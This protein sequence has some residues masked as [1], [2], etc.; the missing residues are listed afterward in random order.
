M[1]SK[2]II[3]HSKDGKESVVV[4]RPLQ[5]RT[6]PLT[7]T[8][9][10]GFIPS[11]K[12]GCEGQV[13]EY[14]SQLEHDFL[15]L[16]DYDPNCLDLQPQPIEFVYKTVSGNLVKFY[17]DIWAVFTD[18]KEYL[19]EVK[20]E[21]HL[22]KLQQDENW[23]RKLAVI[24]DECRK[25]GWIFQIITEKRIRCPRLTNIKQTLTAAKH[26]SLANLKHE[27]QEK[28]ILKNLRKLLEKNKFNLRELSRSLASISQFS[29]EETISILKYQIYYGN[30]FI[31]WD[32]PLEENVVSLNEIFIIPTYKLPEIETRSDNGLLIDED[33]VNDSYISEN[34]TNWLTDSQLNLIQPLIDVFGEKVSKKDIRTL[35]KFVNR[36][37]SEIN[38]YYIT[39]KNQRKYEQRL[40]LITPLINK[41]GKEGK[42]KP[43]ENYCKDQLKMTDSKMQKA[44]KWYIIWRKFDKEGLF[45]KKRSPYKSRLDPLVEQLLQEAVEGWNESSGRQIKAAYESFMIECLKKGFPEKKIPSLM[46]FWDRTQKLPAVEVHGKF[47]AKKSITVKRGLTATYREGLHPGCVIQIDHTQADIW[48]VDD[49]TKQPFC[50][51]WITLAVDVFSRSIWGIFVSVDPPS[52]ESVAQCLLSGLVPK[53]MLKDWQKFQHQMLKDGID[54]EHYQW[55]SSGFPARIQVD[56]GKDFMANS[57]KSFCMRLNIT[58]EFRPIKTPEYGGFV[59]SVWDTINDAIRNDTLLGRVFSLPKSREP[60]KRPKFRTPNGYD[61]KKD[62]ALTMEDFREWLFTYLITRYSTD[63]RARQAHSPNE[64]W[65]DGITGENYQ[66]LG[67]ALRSIDIGEWKQLDY[68]S[69]IEVDSI[70]SRS[71][72]R[73]RNIYYSSEWLIEAR[74]SKLLKD[75]T[76]IIF[77]ISN[78]DRRFAW[79]RDPDTKE[80][81]SL[82]AYKHDKDDRLTKF[83]L[84]GLGEGGYEPFRISKSLLR[85]AELALGET[86]YQSSEGLLILDRTVNRIKTRAKTNKIEQKRFQQLLKTPKGRV[87]LLSSIQPEEEQKLLPA[88]SDDIID[89]ELHENYEIV[90]KK[91]KKSDKQVVEFPTEVDD[92]AEWVKDVAKG[93]K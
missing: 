46:T 4:K 61:P 84:A 83:L 15:L 74:K 24:L 53:K 71:G 87:E 34:R 36:P 27:K 28:N 32:K 31:D 67:G 45:P 64:I 5:T 78:W 76:R 70:L 23:K 59:E 77:R 81:R 63:T 29:F 43:I 19:F 33:L 55:N 65:A 52:Q 26:Y 9:N 8:S 68:L 90:E 72:L 49:F 82:C 18:W 35:A 16:L 56:N 58:L 50:R 38:S 79:V 3:Y 40:A 39:W 6:I 22:A 57:I 12:R 17:P 66:P 30:L 62:A 60:C 25:R 51:P 80:I 2:S 48:I 73:H 41:F 14:E 75:G 88:R 21:S 20:T 92:I 7:T 13:W 44:Y 1:T 10:R 69:K 85:T 86:R 54:P 42:K 89:I 37:F 93:E 11:L 47:P 91:S